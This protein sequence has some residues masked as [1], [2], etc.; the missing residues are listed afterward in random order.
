M[1]EY[2]KILKEFEHQ[3]TTEA[4]GVQY[5]YILGWPNGFTC[6]RRAAGK[7]WFTGRRLCKCAAYGYQIAAKARMIF[8]RP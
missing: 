6:L 5:S 2:P 7:A 4:A 3:F 1:E 8:E